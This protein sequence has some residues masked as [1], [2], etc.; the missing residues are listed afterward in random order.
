MNIHSALYETSPFYYSHSQSSQSPKT[1]SPAALANG[2]S[3]T[4]H[5]PISIVLSLEYL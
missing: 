1:P 2:A 3:T 4:G 5:Y